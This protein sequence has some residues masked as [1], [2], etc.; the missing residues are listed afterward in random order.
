MRSILAIGLLLIASVS[1]AQSV[2]LPL[3]EKLQADTSRKSVKTFAATAWGK[4]SVVIN[5][6]APAVRNR[7]IWGGLVPYTEVWVTGAHFATQIEFREKVMVNG[8]K[9][10]KGRYALFTIPRQND[11]IVIINKNWQQ[12]LTDEYDPK[13]DAVRITVQPQTTCPQAERLQ[14]GFS[15]T[16]A[17]T[18][19]LYMRWEKLQV[20]VP[21]SR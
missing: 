18:G 1:F 6:Y 10:D 2:C 14:W 21:V 11:W 4:D 19:L 16:D 7:T 20:A 12:H 15:A 5:W 17:A 8:V 3:Y 9:L 13:D